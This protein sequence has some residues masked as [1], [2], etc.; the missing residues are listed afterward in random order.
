M[1]KCP[2]CDAEL[3]AVTNPANSALNDDQF[4]AVR[5]GDWYC[6]NVTVDHGEHAER[7]SSRYAYFWTRELTTVAETHNG[8]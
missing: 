4:D 3:I 7:S 2:V 8:L 6:K 1:I 5:V